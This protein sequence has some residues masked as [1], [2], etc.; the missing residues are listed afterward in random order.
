MKNILFLVFICIATVI[1]AQEPDP[2][3]NDKMARTEAQSYTKSASFVEAPENAFYDLVYQRLNLEVDPAV[4]HIAGSV[5]S[6]VKL[7]RENLAELYFDMST[8][9]TVDS[10]RFGQD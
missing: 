6:K 5:V 2:D 8:A 10:V 1:W 9:L 4:R 7:L 3:F